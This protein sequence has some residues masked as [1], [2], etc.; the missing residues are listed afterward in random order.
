MP[1]EIEII[2]TSNANTV[3]KIPV[4]NGFA[5]MSL[6][7]NFKDIPK[8]SYQ[9]MTVFVDSKKFLNLWRNTIDTLHKTEAL[10][11]EKSWRK[12]RKFNWAEV[13]F[14]EGINNPVPLAQAMCQQYERTNEPSLFR[15]ILGEKKISETI[16]YCAFS[17]GVTRTIWLLANDAK[18]FPVDVEFS[19]YHRMKTHAGIVNPIF[20]YSS[21]HD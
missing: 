16:P 2:T 10:G 18:F 5:Y 1:L 14:S 8:E 19:S 20:K 21:S 17:D 15:R 12:D 11:N 3:C 6:R 4:R 13:G 7:K 9:F